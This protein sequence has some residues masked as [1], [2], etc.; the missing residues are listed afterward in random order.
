MENK[1]FEDDKT[2]IAELQTRITTTSEL[3]QS[4]DEHSMDGLEN[5][6]VIMKT[7]RMGTFRLES[8][9]SYVADYAIPNFYFHLSSAYCILRHLGVPINA[10]DYLGKDTFVKA[11]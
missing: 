3:L 2:T 1:Y 4:I 10:M 7:T 8:G 11:E 6:P 9:Q 5:K